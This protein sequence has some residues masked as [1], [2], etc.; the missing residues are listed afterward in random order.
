MSEAEMDGG[1]VGSC[2]GWVGDGGRVECVVPP[3]PLHEDAV[4]L[5]REGRE[6]GREGGLAGGE[7]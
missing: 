5:G 7:G 6:E 4:E 2:A 3:P 1:G